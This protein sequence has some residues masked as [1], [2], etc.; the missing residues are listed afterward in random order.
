MSK[1]TQSHITETKSLKKFLNIIPDH[2]VVR[3]LSERRL[4][5]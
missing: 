3:E 5:H 1:R 2:W 4:R